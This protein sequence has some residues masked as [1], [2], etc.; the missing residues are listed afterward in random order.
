VSK[1]FFIDDRKYFTLR[2]EAFNALNHPN[3]GAPNSDISDPNSFGKITNTFS[4][5]RIVELV[6]KFNF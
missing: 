3:W 1:N 5:P 6:L 2:V 4:A